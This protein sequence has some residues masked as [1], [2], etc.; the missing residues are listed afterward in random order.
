MKNIDIK[1]N[2]KEDGS[3]PNKRNKCKHAWIPPTCTSTHFSISLK[4]RNSVQDIQTKIKTWIKHVETKT[5]R[6]LL[7][8]SPAQ[9]VHDS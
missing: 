8:Q 6:L 4:A 7:L 9:V 1:D 3:R 2:N 5:H